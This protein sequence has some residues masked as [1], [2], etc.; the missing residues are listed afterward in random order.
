MPLTV[1]RVVECAN[2]TPSLALT[3]VRQQTT[4]IDKHTVD[5]NVAARSAKVVLRKRPLSAMIRGPH[6]AVFWLG[7][8]CLVSSC[9]AGGF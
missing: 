5:K 1:G 7:A 3:P 4:R 8:V 2:Q 6:A 9:A